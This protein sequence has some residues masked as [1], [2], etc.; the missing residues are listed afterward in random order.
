MLNGV[1]RTRR[2]PP[3][4]TPPS[5]K[6]NDLVATLKDCSDDYNKRVPGIKHKITVVENNVERFEFLKEGLEYM[7]IELAQV[8]ARINQINNVLNIKN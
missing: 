5:Y 3:A 1:K 4:S 8:N 2:P 6:I 7:K